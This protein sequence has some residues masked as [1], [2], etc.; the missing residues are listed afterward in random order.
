MIL[1]AS[2]GLASAVFRVIQAG[3]GAGEGGVVW[4]FF[5]C[6]FFV[7]FTRYVLYSDGAV[8]ACVLQTY[9]QG[10]PHSSGSSYH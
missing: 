6:V 4:F 10:L 5:F 9:V 8:P 7:F 2:P 3:V 1:L